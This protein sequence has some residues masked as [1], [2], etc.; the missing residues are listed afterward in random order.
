VGH[1]VSILPLERAKPGRRLC[2]IDT[3]SETTP[4]ADGPKPLSPGWAYEEKL[5][6]WR[7]VATK[8]GHRGRLVSRTDT[9]HTRTFPGVA[10]AIAALPAETLILDGEVCGFDPALVSHIRLLHDAEPGEIATPP[11]GADVLGAGEGRLRDPV[12]RGLVAR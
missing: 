8:T 9:D 1:A 12:F 6:G 3:A 11:G 5:D 2:I 7:I 4:R 10:A